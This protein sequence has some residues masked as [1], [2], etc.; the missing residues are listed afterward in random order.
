M[1]NGQITTLENNVLNFPSMGV[2]I[3]VCATDLS[4]KNSKPAQE[5]LSCT[6][7]HFRSHPGLWQHASHFNC[8]NHRR[9]D[10][11]ERPLFIG[12]SATRHKRKYSILVFRHLPDDLSLH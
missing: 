4:T 9:Q 12:S 8:P 1:C 11:K 2:R 7:Q 10:H 3:G 6:R 5:K